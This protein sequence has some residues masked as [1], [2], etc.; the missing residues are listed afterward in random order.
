LVVAVTGLGAPVAIAQTW[1][2]A[3]N[4][5]WNNASNWSSLPINFVDASLTFGATNNAVLN[6]NLANPFQVGQ[7]TFNAGAPAYFVNGNPI[8]FSNSATSFTGIIAQNSSNP[9]TFNAPI[10]ITSGAGILEL[11]G[12]GSGTVTLNGV[13]SGGTVYHESAAPLFITNA[14]NSTAYLQASAGTTTITNPTAIGG[15]QVDT[16]AVVKLGF[17]TG[18]NSAAPVGIN[19]NGG[20]V[21]VPAGSADYYVGFINGGGNLDFTGSTDFWMHFTG[22]TPYINMATV[23]GIYSWIGANQSRI[24]NDGTAPLNV[25]MNPGTLLTSS[26]SFANG[27]TGQPIM[28]HGGGTLVLTSINNSANLIIDSGSTL[29]VQDVACLG[30]GT[31]TLQDTFGLITSPATHGRLAYTG[32]TAT[33]AKNI[34]L[35]SGGGGTIVVSQPGA[36]LTLSGTIGESSA[37]QGLAISGP[38]I[39]ASSSVVT[40]TGTNTYS[41]PTTVFGGGIL[42]AN[43]VTNVGT[44][45]PIGAGGDLVLGLAANGPGTFSY[46]GPTASTDHGITF[47]SSASDPGT[48]QVQS[49]GTNLTVGGVVVGNLNK[50][51]AGTL[52]LTNGI[53]SVT[54]ANV[55]AGTLAIGGPTAIG[56]VA[57]VN[58]AAGATFQNASGLGDNS[59]APLTALNL[60]GG[61]Y[62]DSAFINDYFVGSITST[63]G[64]A[65]NL[66]GSTNVGLHLAATTP[67][68]TVTD[69]ATWTGGGTSHMQDDGGSP[70]KIAISPGV[71]LN[72]GIVLN[73]GLS[74]LGF[75]ITGGG[76]LNQTA[77]AA[78]PL[79]ISNGTL[80][81]AS[82]TI[83]QT[84]IPLVLDGGTFNYAGPT[85]TLTR[86]VNVTANG[87]TLTVSSPTAN[88]Q[89]TGAIS[90]NGFLAKEGPGT[91]ALTNAGGF[92][93]TALVDTGVLQLQG[94]LGGTSAIAI[95]AGGN[96]QYAASQSTGRTFNLNYGT[97]SVIGGTTL[98][99]NAATVN[100]G[101]VTGPGTFTATGGTAF[102]GVTTTP[103]AVINQLSGATF[104]NVTN[105]GALSVASG[106]ANPGSFNRFTN[107]GSGSVTL[108][109]SSALTA[110]EFQTYGTLTI[111]PATVTETYSQ[112][113]PMTNVG[114]TPLYFNG[115][116]RTFIGTPATAVF[117]N[118]WPDASLRGTPTF[119]AG[120]DLNGKN[121][122]VAGGLFVNN[123]YV[124]DSSN[125]YTGA[126]TVVADFGALVKG[127]GFFQNSVQTINGGKFQAGNS[128]GKAMFGSFVFGPGGV[129]NYV[130]AIDD[131]SGAA[132]PRPDAQGHVSGWGLVKTFAPAGVGVSKSG[133]GDFNWTATPADKLTVSVDTLINP[134][135][136]GI[137]VPGPMDHFD[138]R[139]SYTW[140]AVEWTGKYAGPMDAAA[141][142]AA[143]SFDTTGFANPIAG[144]FGWSLDAADHMLSLTYT[145][146][147]VPE[148]GTLA[149]TGLA[150]IGWVGYWRRRW[151]RV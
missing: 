4:G 114:T 64:G 110:T 102:N 30:S 81:V 136:V 24:Q 33:L 34:T 56:P 107:Q 35:G 26:I 100:G 145:P 8:E 41:G 52:T 129:N 61:T 46:Q 58:V 151:A 40:L 29:Q 18:N 69:N 63:S 2:G 146:S 44:P 106:S 76:T 75:Q 128:P 19:L 39:T 67:S 71:T 16:G 9:V 117:P 126:G 6:Q 125:G 77:T 84:S 94:T 127:A 109:A 140:P 86:P 65:V 122:I 5:N 66:A 98:N 120:I 60:N 27:T 104:V 141:L 83:L 70:A 105:G 85:D 73:I 137:D 130:F 142:N 10:N 116:S 12:T 25:V 31:L 49:A 23:P 11:N 143:T 91:L 45:G 124:E 89:L 36:N 15:F 108:A 135:T 93:G 115:G 150:A 97:L 32:S 101:F 54:A 92:M 90:G 48:V 17:T 88:L 14:G 78:A 113:T 59:G 123:G 79:T 28:V 119:V 99:L 1:S 43:S 87:G 21:A 148:P 132:G 20:T 138:P 144:N 37:N 55:L 13:I 53:N 131:A 111:N 7:M 95:N 133:T 42:A 80:Q 103:S 50:T 57:T 96:L 134:T 82:T 3:A 22:S 68:I 139:L 121:A 38:N 47:S 62:A 74:G 149:L 112:T 118:T 72:N 51:G 147:A